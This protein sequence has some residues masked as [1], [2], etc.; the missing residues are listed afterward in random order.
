METKKNKKRFGVQTAV[1]VGC[2][3]I[4]WIAYAEGK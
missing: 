4:A 3:L 2:A 1:V